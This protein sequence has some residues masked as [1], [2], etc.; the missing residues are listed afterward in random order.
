MTPFEL[1]APLDPE[2]ESTGG[3]LADLAGTTLAGVFAGVTLSADVEAIYIRDSKQRATVSVESK[4]N[5][6]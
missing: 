5:R 6:A 2:D 4:S 1:P 3:V